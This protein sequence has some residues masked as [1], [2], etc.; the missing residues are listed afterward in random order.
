MR[1]TPPSAQSRTPHVG[2]S[3]ACRTSDR[4]TLRQK[5]STR[6]ALDMEKSQRLAK[7]SG[8][9][10]NSE[11][12]GLPSDAM[13][14]GGQQGDFGTDG[15]AGKDKELQV[16]VRKGMPPNASRAERRAT[17]ISTT[18]IRTHLEQQGVVLKGATEEKKA[19]NT[20]STEQ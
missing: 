1:P 6:R 9:S 11:P 18:D 10:E 16:P 15:C 5:L 7:A 3:A 12:G 19:E 8:S 13:E 14:D 20:D 2:L 4:R 17:K